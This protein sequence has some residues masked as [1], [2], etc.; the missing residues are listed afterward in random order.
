MICVCGEKNAVLRLHQYSVTECKYYAICINWG[1]AEALTQSHT[2]TCHRNETFFAILCLQRQFIFLLP[3]FCHFY[4]RKIAHISSI[5]ISSRSQWRCNEKF[6]ILVVASYVTMASLL[7]WMEKIERKRLKVNRVALNGAPNFNFKAFHY[8]KK[9]YL[10][11][12]LLDVYSL[13]LSSTFQHCL[14]T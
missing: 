3:P 1:V 13:L 11:L 12:I 2:L 8:H 14:H 9:E 4:E 5:K 6:S 7:E 10:H